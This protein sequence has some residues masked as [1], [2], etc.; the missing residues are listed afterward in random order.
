M[1]KC[2]EVVNGLCKER[3]TFFCKHQVVGDT[4]GDSFWEN[5]RV[6]EKGIQRAYASNIEV[7]I[8]ATIMV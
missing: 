8:D 6:N 2:H 4:D 1:V 5:D 7:E 3:V